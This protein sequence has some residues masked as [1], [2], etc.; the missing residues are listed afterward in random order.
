MNYCGEMVEKKY[1]IE[2]Y[3]TVVDDYV[4]SQI[5]LPSVSYDM[6]CI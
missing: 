3:S 2:R 6:T 4:L 5:F 1:L